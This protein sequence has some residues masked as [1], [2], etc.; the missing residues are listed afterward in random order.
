VNDVSESS[1]TYGNTLSEY[2]RMDNI[3]ASSRLA[4]GWSSNLAMLSLTYYWTELAKGN[5]ADGDKLKEYYD[6]F[7]ILAIAAQIGIDSSKRVYS[8][9]AQ[10]EVI[11]IQNLPCMQYIRYEIDVNGKK[12]KYKYDL[13][14]FMKYVREPAHT[15]DGNL[16]PYEVVKKNKTK[17]N[18]RINPEF[19]CP[20]NWLV[21]CLDRT[22]IRD[23][24][25]TNT[26]S[27]KEFFIKENGRAN[28]SQMSK[29]RKLIDEYDGYVRTISN[30]SDDETTKTV[31]LKTEEIIEAIRGVKMG[32]A[33]I[34]RLIETAL[35][36]EDIN[37]LFK[38]IQGL[39]KKYRRRFLNYIYRSNQEYFLKCF[40]NN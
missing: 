2:A 38:D 25:R 7:V 9:S 27:I 1:L 19:I 13:P 35:G 14:K 40:K 24:S 30:D 32:A 34:N 11:R 6:I 39:N 36:I 37:G 22:R 17:L 18:K 4:I 16:I 20:M 12:K 23:H 33:T 29:I 10:E 15:K 31:M 28:Y 21:E 8:V 5:Q 3:L 26:V